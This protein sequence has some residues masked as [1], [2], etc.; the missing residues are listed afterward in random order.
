MTEATKDRLVYV[1]VAAVLLAL[2]AMVA[3]LAAG[4]MLGQYVVAGWIG[5]LTVPAACWLGAGFGRW[6]CARANGER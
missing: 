5:A 4:W 2:P 1:W 6:F 3:A